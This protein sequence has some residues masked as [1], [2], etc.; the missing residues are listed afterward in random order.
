MISEMMKTRLA[1]ILTASLW[2]LIVAVWLPTVWVLLQL[3]GT[4]N[5]ND[6]SALTKYTEHELQTVHY[7]IDRPEERKY[8]FL[9]DDASPR[10]QTSLGDWFLPIALITLFVLA[11]PYLLTGRVTLKFSKA[12]VHDL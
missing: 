3:P 8:G 2:L 5:G 7:H 11:G 1:N 4:W 10:L 12:E 9:F 6:V